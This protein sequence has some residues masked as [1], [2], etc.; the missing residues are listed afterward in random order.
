MAS[1]KVVELSS[2][3]WEQEV[4]QSDR[5]VLVDFWGPGCPPCSR[6][7][8]VID[9]LAD[10]YADRLKVGKVNAQQDME[11]AVRYGIASIPQVFFFH[12]SPQPR[13]RFVGFTPEG[14]LDKAIQR[15]LGT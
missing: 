15:V 5:P 14:E 1:P 3:N 7:A 11:L 8:L 13:E 9:R 4:I 12:G 10:R 6:L 2:A